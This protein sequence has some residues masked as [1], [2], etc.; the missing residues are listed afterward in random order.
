[1]D[2]D[3][4]KNDTIKAMIIEKI[5]QQ[6]LS[7]SQQA[8]MSDEDVREELGK[9]LHAVCLQFPDE[10]DRD[11]NPAGVEFSEVMFLAESVSHSESEKVE[12]KDIH[13]KGVNK[14]IAKVMDES[15]DLMDYPH[16]RQ[17]IV[18]AITTS[19]SWRDLYDAVSYKDLIDAKVIELTDVK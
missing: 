15:D 19:K 6:R 18:D 12:G 1:M 2:A 7:A 3:A 8:T 13:E 17:K 16:L 10:N 14:L 4:M 11:T 9:Y 5:R